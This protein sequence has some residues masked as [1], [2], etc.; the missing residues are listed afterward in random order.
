MLALGH[1]WG[2][3]GVTGDGGRVLAASIVVLPYGAANAGARDDLSGGCAWVSM[4]LVSPQF[5]RLGHASQLL[6]HALAWLY[7]KGATPVLDAT[8]AGYPVYL[9]EG[10]TPTWG[11]RRYRR[12]ATRAD[13]AS[14]DAAGPARSPDA[15][16]AAHVPYTRA[17]TA[18]DWPAI[19]AYDAPAFGGER[20]RLLR[21]LAARMPQAARIAE[22]GGDIAGFVL[23]R[24]GREACQIGP[25]LADDIDVAQRLLDDVLDTV[26][27]PVY[28]DLADRY[29]SLLPRLAARG[30]IEQRPFTR[31][32]HGATTAPGDPAR[33]VLVAGPELG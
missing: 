9:Q 26:A 6:R 27:H 29:R 13:P 20:E 5:R 32:V 15:A 23:G 1:G 4:V 7:A 28:V 33:V 2:I 21:T 24:D 18:D 22:R 11:F 14:P 16:G 30:F 10:F 3:E 19:A 25:L 12:E 8:P 31:M 17:I